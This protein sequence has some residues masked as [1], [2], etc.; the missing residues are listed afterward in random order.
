VTMLHLARNK[1]RAWN[2]PLQ[3]DQI[4]TQ[5]GL[6]RRI[7]AAAFLQ[8]ASLSP[9]ALA[10]PVFVLLVMREVDTSGGEQRDDTGGHLRTSK[11]GKDDLR[12]DD[13]GKIDAC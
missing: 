12:W 13:R 8:A 6:S 7:C 5:L 10:S 3:A 4:T 2:S 11:G 1:G 9:A